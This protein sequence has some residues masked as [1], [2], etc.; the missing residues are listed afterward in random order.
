MQREPRAVDDYET[1][2]TLWR[3]E[4]G[5]REGVAD[6]QGYPHVFVSEWDE[7]ADS[8]GDAFLLKPIDDETFRLVMEDW[9]IWRRSSVTFQ[10]ETSL[11][12]HPVSAEDGIR[13]EE[14]KQLLRERLTVDPARA[15]QSFPV[16]T[17]LVDQTSAVNPAEVVR[18]AAE[19]CS[20]ADPAH[21]DGYL[22]PL[23]GVR[24]SAVGEPS[25]PAKAKRLSD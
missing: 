21:W 12:T 2:W 3:Y 14:L 11:A 13:R 19:F 9:A 16:Q 23:M 18:V 10:G 24:W 7:E 17:W 4:D 1:V 5:P 25:S 6:Y 20:R 22:L 8:Y 15:R